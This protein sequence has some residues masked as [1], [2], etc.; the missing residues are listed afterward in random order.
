MS[1]RLD[2]RNVADRIK[3]LMR[4]RRLTAAEFAKRSGMAEQSLKNIL[5]GANNPQFRTVVKI[6]NAFNTSLDWLC[7]EVKD[8]EELE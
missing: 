5:N 4:D 1:M 7:K 6:A 8:T 2:E 3:M